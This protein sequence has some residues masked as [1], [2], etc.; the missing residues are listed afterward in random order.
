MDE[1]A[2]QK[3]LDAIDNLG[4]EFYEVIPTDSYNNAHYSFKDGFIIQTICASQIFQ[5]N[6]NVEKMIVDM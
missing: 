5:Y 6:I 1:D 3:V 2:H 4:G